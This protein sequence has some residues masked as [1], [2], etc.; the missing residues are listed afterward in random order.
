[1][2]IRIYREALN[3]Q[4]GFEEV[5]SELRLL[6]ERSNR[7]NEAIELFRELVGRDST[8]LGDKVQ[9]GQYLFQK[10]DT[11]AAAQ[12][13]EKIIQDHPQSERGYL[14]LGALRRAQRDTLAAM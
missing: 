14:A 4:S 6:Y 10:K 5:K 3:R 1:G 8:H 11:L 2:A 9:L 12:W 13:F 7:L